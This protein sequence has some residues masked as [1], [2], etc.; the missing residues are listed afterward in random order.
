MAR[1]VITHRDGSRTVYFPGGRVAHFH[2]PGTKAFRAGQAAK[3][4]A[5]RK[6]AKAY[7]FTKKRT[8]K[9]GKR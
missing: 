8:T 6:L 4:A 5:G 3:R 9:R 7:G 1:K 2:K